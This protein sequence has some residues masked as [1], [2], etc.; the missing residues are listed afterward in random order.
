MVFMKIS[1]SIITYNEE[2]HIRDAIRSLKFADE[3]VVV[4]S[5]STD[6]TVD[7]CA[8]LDV[9]VFKQEWLGFGRQKQD[10]RRPLLTRVDI[11]P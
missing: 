6:K 4:D 11:Q 9:K 2:N 3:I 1:A 8:E 7:I 10:G 5:G